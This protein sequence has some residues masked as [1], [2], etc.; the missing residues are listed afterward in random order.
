MPIVLAA[1][2]KL[3]ATRSR[4][5]KRLSEPS[6]AAGHR[7][8]PSNQHS[9]DSTLQLLLT[10]DLRQRLVISRRS[11]HKMLSTYVMK[12]LL[13]VKLEVREHLSDGGQP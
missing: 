1:K 8:V 9:P 2:I 4:A 10:Y 12:F 5:E 7:R 6:T 11:G 3:R 13:N